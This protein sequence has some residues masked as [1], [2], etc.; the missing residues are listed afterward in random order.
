MITFTGFKKKKKKKN[1][2]R[3]QI[4]VIAAVILC[5][6]GSMV[7]F[8]YLLMHVNRTSDYQG[9]VKLDPSKTNSV[10]KKTDEEVNYDTDFYEYTLSEDEKSRLKELG[11]TDEQIADGNVDSFIKDLYGIEAYIQERYMNRYP[12]PYKNAKN[13]TE[14]QCSA[15]YSSMLSAYLDGNYSNVVYQFQQ[16]LKKYTFV[17]FRCEPVTSL[18]HDAAARI[19][20]GLLKNGKEEGDDTAELTAESLTDMNSAEALLYDTFSSGYVTILPLIHDSS[21][22]VPVTP[23]AD[24]IESRVYDPQKDTFDHQEAIGRMAEAVYYYKAEDE[25][26]QPVNVYIESD[27]IIKK[28]V[29][30][31]YED[32][33]G[34]ILKASLQN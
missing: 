16:A 4:A 18:Y 33:S 29:G 23:L 13:P 30:V 6:T 27:G 21:S 5:M 7:M 19:D 10:K 3:K 9:V 14:A 8:N 25:N 11:Y 26:G 31:Y 20:Q 32:S 15:L 24:V 1:I 28:I 22:C 12:S 17:E 2:K 34:C